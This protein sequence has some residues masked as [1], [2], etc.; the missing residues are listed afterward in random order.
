MRAFRWQ[1]A[2][3]G[4]L[5]QNRLEEQKQQPGLLGRIFRTVDEIVIDRMDLIGEMFPKLSRFM[6]GYNLARVYDGNQGR[7]NLNYLIS[8]SEGTLVFISEARL[9]LTPIPLRRMLLLI[10]YESFDDALR[11]AARLVKSDPTAIETIDE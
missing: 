10:R 6:S 11:D 2:E 7:F 5:D 3:L 8:G 4:P 9:R 1:A